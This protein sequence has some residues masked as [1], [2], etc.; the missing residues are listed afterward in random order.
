MFYSIPGIFSFYFIVSLYT[1][2]YTVG[3]IMT[4]IEINR[5]LYVCKGKRKCLL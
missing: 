4:L 1:N 3:G 5:R 2:I